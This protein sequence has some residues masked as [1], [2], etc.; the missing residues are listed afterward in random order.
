MSEEERKV[1]RMKERDERGRGSGMRRERRNKEEEGWTRMGRKEGNSGEDKESI[2][3]GRD[4]E[5]RE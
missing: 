2:E 3:A 5:G 4:D 1:V